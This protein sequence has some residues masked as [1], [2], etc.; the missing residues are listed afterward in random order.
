M[1]TVPVQR[2]AEVPSPHIMF[3]GD[4]PEAAALAFEQKFQ[5]EAPVVYELG[6]RV[7]IPITLE[8]ER[9]WSA[10]ENGV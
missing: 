1:K 8:P 2:E 7:F 10:M 3:I 4:S 5:Q 6:K 9:F